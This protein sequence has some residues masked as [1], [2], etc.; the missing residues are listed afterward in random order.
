MMQ[1]KEKIYEI[2]Q[3]IEMPQQKSGKQIGERILGRSIS[4]GE[5]HTHHYSLEIEQL[6]KY[7]ENNNQ[8][9]GITLNQEPDTSDGWKQRVVRKVRTAVV[10]P[11]VE[12]DN[13]FHASVTCSLNHLYNN[14]IIL[15]KF[16]DEQAEVI[17]R[18]EEELAQQRFV[19]M[20]NE[21]KIRELYGMLESKHSEGK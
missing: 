7:I 3:E 1:T 18:L 19:N 5:L 10:S 14:M 16:A 17:Q 15:Q 13:A 9:Y 4:D 12:Q 20:V 6:K 2:M 21:E 8:I 11:V